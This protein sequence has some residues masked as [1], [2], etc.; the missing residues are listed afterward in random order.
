MVVYREKGMKKNGK[1]IFIR[2]LLILISLITLIGTAGCGSHLDTDDISTSGSSKVGVSAYHP[3]GGDKKL[4]RVEPDGD[5]KIK[6]GRNSK[7]N[8]FDGEIML[9]F[10]GTTYHR[11]Q[12]ASDSAAPFR[13]LAST[14]YSSLFSSEGQSRSLNDK[15]DFKPR[16]YNNE[17][18][19]A[20]NLEP[21][22]VCKGLA[23]ETFNLISKKGNNVF[24]ELLNALKG[25]VAGIL[26]IFWGVQFV[27]QILQERFTMESLLK[28]MCF[29]II[30]IMITLTAQNFA[31]ALISG[32]N[33]V[34]SNLTQQNFGKST[35]LESFRNYCW[36]VTN[37]TVIYFS[38]TIVVFDNPSIRIPTIWIDIGSVLG[39][40]VMV[41]PF[42]GQLICAYQIVTQMI[43]RMLE[44]IVRVA[45]APIPIAFGSAQG[46]GPSSMSF[47]KGTL[48]VAMQPVLIMIGA[49]SKDAILSIITGNSVLN[50]SSTTM[51]SIVGSVMVF[52]SYLVLSGFI[53]QTKQISQEIIAR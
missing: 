51:G 48:A 36:E 30:G 27:T 50:I 38:A 16:L 26:V 15:K 32:A 17:P 31:G 40:L 24:N 28:G 29:L 19:P 14:M 49:M 23:T 20:I 25:L 35:A 37:G 41:L 53:G 13:T 4:I 45:L 11:A 22:A 2:L 46:F 39:T 43:T 9:A 6:V 21:Y 44:L 33:N 8:W 18:K 12:E 10:D 3:E 52:L 5:N 1:K 34:V 42:L 7:Q 47:L